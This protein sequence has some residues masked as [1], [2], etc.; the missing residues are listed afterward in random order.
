[1]RLFYDYVYSLLVDRFGDLGYA[2]AGLS[3]FGRKS[4]TKE[5]NAKKPYLG[6]HTD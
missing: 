1:M 2:T 6:L 3:V 4:L 5:E